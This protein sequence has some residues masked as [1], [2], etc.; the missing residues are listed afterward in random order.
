M[1]FFLRLII[2][3]VFDILQILIVI[4][5]FL[6]WVPHD[7]RGQYAIILYTITESIFEPIRFILPGRSI[8]FDLA[9]IIVFFLLGIIKKILL[10]A[11]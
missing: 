3:N 7:S 2:S 10:V 5:V 8:G 6:S 11:V 1:D 9:P 4:R